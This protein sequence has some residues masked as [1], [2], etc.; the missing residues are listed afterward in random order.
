MKKME[1]GVKLELSINCR[2]LV[3]F[4]VMNRCEEQRLCVCELEKD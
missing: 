3:M 2:V 1:N 4:E